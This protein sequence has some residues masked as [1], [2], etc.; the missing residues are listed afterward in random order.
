MAKRNYKKK[1]TKKNWVVKR[2]YA[3]KY[4]SGVPGKQRIKMVYLATGV[5]AV[6]TGVSPS[7]FD[8]Q[9]YNMNNLTQPFPT[10]GHQPR[11]MS[12]M[13]ILY[14]KYRVTGV[15]VEIEGIVTTTNA[16]AQIFISPIASGGAVPSGDL[17]MAE[18]TKNSRIVATNNR[19]FKMKRYFSVA[20]T[21]CIKKS[22]FETESDYVGGTSGGSLVPVKIPK[23]QIGVAALILTD[24]VTV[25]YRVRMTY[26]TEFFA[27]RAVAAS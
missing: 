9:V 14:L 24:P 20:K 13:A 11:Y 17:A 7:Y 16:A 26:Y 27:P 3:P 4:Q 2:Q 23:F 15:L 10:G 19:L 12:Q 1:A 25:D 5:T 22:Y 6:V 18:Y 8:S 21:D